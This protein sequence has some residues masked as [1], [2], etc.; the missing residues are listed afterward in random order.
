MSVVL[1]Q[2]I[3]RWRARTAELDQSGRKT[4]SWQKV[5]FHF[6]TGMWSLHLAPPAV[7]IVS[8]TPSPLM[9][10][11]PLSPGI[12]D[13]VI[14]VVVVLVTVRR[15]WSGGT[16]NSTMKQNVTTQNVCD[17]LSHVSRL[18]ITSII[19]VKNTF[20]WNW[21]R[22]YTKKCIWYNIFVFSLTHNSLSKWKKFYTEIFFSCLIKKKKTVN[23][24]F[25]VF[26]SLWLLGPL[27]FK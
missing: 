12:H 1:E 14:D 17:I 26:L 25:Y 22:K 8:V 16:V 5:S 9:E 20:T 2:Q 19:L 7:R 15:G 6:Y 21:E 27:V 11:P 23:E 13:N 3:M 18:R 24:Y 10:L 4:N